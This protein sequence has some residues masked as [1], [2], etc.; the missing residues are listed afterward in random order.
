MTLKPRISRFSGDAPSSFPTLRRSS[1]PSFLWPSQSAA[2][3][4]KR[5]PVTPEASLPAAAPGAPIEDDDDFFL[6]S[7]SILAPQ[8]GSGA[9]IKRRRTLERRDSFTFSPFSPPSTTNAE[10]VAEQRC[11]NAAPSGATAEQSSEEEDYDESLLLPM[12][13]AEGRAP[14][15]TLPFCPRPFPGR[16][17]APSSLEDFDEARLSC[18]SASRSL[19]Q[20]PRLAPHATTQDGYLTPKKPMS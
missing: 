11:H 8:L 16:W 12:L 7:P 14:H 20:L 4:R 9:G 1:P 6:A 19:L 18:P 13:S 3:G 17:I 2:A 5:R 15:P 10:T